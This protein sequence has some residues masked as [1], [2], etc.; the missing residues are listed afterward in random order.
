MVW[1][2]SLVRPLRAQTAEPGT[3]DWVQHFIG[4][5]NARGKDCHIPE[6][7]SRLVGLP[8]QA[9][10]DREIDIWRPEIRA[11]AVVVVDGEISL[12]VSH[13]SAND[14]WMFRVSES[15][16]IERAIWVSPHQ[17][18]HMTDDQAADQLNVEET[19]WSDWAGKKR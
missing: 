11:L 18:H 15:G 14:I 2:S 19:W 4:V 8:H 10:P 7:T 5:V 16:S 9:F 1:F 3:S 12:L 13:G 6:K 17:V